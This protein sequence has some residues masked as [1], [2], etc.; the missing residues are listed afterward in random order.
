[1]TNEIRDTRYEI[2]DTRY[3]I[4]DTRYEAATIRYTGQLAIDNPYDVY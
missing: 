1:M 4:R 3:E 2:R